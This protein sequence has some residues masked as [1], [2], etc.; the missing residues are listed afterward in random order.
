MFH[1]NLSQFDHRYL[2]LVNAIIRPPRCRY[3]IA[4]LG[5][6]R[7]QCGGVGMT[8]T[9]VVLRCPT[10]GRLMLSEWRP[11]GWE[12]RANANPT[13]S[14]FTASNVHE[15]CPPPALIYIHGNAGGRCDV[16]SNGLLE[17]CAAR[18]WCL[19]ALDCG[20]SG[21]SDSPHVTL[22]HYESGDLAIAVQYARGTPIT[23]DSARACRATDGGAAAAVDPAGSHGNGDDGNSDC[24]WPLRKIALYG[25]SMGGATAILYCQRSGGAY[26][27]A[28]VVDSSFS[29]L[30]SLALTHPECC[31]IK[32]ARAG[33]VLLFPYVRGSVWR[34]TG[35][36][37][38]THVHLNIA[39]AAAQV[40]PSLPAAFISAGGDPIVPPSHSEELLEVWRGEPKQRWHL[41]DPRHDHNSPRPRGTL[42]EVFDFIAPFLDSGDGA[43]LD[44]RTSSRG[45]TAGEGGFDKNRNK[46]STIDTAGQRVEKGEASKEGETRR[47]QNTDEANQGSGG[48]DQLKEAALQRLATKEA[49]QKSLCTIEIKPWEASQDLPALFAKIQ[50]TMVRDN[51]TWS[52]Q[53]KLVEVGYGVRK[54]VCTAVIGQELSM[55]A[56]IEDMVEDTFADEIQ[57]MEMTSMSLL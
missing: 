45:S 54:I 8:R 32:G 49:R 10:R 20:G 42:N 28:V 16:L 52:E 5:P 35:R 31:K 50:A 34:R 3:E 44:G 27:S 14:D 57:S 30:R 11:E 9:D 53:C 48:D 18:G 36:G 26:V 33:L 56:I 37:L 39:K 43:P 47:D 21:M 17:M 19:I 13:Q 55:D 40:S 24:K 12:T 25:F 38:D 41:D 6:L 51:L 15:Q 23:P 29:S 7:V 46:S 22:G 4:D 2:S 1:L